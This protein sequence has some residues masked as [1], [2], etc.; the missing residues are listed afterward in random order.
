[1]WKK[2]AVPQPDGKW[3][4]KV[5]NLD[6]GL[7]YQCVGAW[8]RKGQRLEWQCGD[9]YAPIPGRETRDMK[10]KDY[11]AL[12]RSTH[13]VVFPTS[14]VE[15]QRNVKTVEAGAQRRPLAEEVGRTWYVRVPD[16]ECAPAARFAE[17]R[18]AFWNLLQATW[19]EVFQQVDGFAEVKLPDAPPRFVRLGEVEERHHAQ[20]ASDE[21]AR[22]TAK[23][24]ILEVIEAYRAR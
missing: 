3:V 18:Q 24:E 4:R 8:Q 7:R 15:R 17:E 19:D 21:R 10:R 1:R 23:K 11:Q 2:Q 6:D 22:A 9:N 12:V 14:W 20:V 16:A 13:L 5:T